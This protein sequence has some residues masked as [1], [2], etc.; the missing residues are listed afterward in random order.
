MQLGPLAPPPSVQRAHR[1]A[2]G[3]VLTFPKKLFVFLV[4]P[5]VVATL[6]LFTLLLT[7]KTTPP[8]GPL[9]RELCRVVARLFAK[10]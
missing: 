9:S 4:Q 6:E 10:W 1:L 8:V 2:S 5:C 3:K 7:S